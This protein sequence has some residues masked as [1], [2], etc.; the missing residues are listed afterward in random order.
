MAI[1]CTYENKKVIIQKKIGVVLG[2]QTSK[3]EVFLSTRTIVLDVRDHTL[4]VD[5]VVMK[6]FLA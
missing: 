6:Y 5:I 4:P 3:Q 1:F 2:W